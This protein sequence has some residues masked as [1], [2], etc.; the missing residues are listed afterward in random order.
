MIYYDEDEEKNLFYQRYKNN[1]KIKTNQKIG[2]NN[3]NNNKNR[4]KTKKRHDSDS[5]TEIEI[6]INENNN[7]VIFNNNN[8]NNIKNPIELNENNNNNENKNFNIENEEIKKIVLGKDEKKEKFFQQ[9]KENIENISK[10]EKG[11]I[12]ENNNNDDENNLNKIDIIKNNEDPMNNIIQLNKKI[13]SEKINNNNNENN[14]NNDNNKKYKRNFYLPKCKYKSVN[15]FNIEAGYRWDG[16]DR[17]NGFEN[18][19]FEML[20]QKKQK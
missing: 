18:K 3:N 9:I 19:Y 20:N 13:E 14:D 17:S 6:K 1:K 10:F 15:R 12:N 2:N 4:N 16:V 11:L 7:K 5:D 8:N